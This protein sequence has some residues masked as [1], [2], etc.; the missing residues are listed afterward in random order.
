MCVEG[1]INSIDQ[2]FVSSLASSMQNRIEM[3][4]ENEGND[5]GY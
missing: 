1:E 4:I 3:L 5:I 2:E